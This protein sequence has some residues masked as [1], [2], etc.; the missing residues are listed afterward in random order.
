[1]K[2]ISLLVLF[3]T[4]NFLGFG[5]VKMDQIGTSVWNKDGNIFADSAISI[6]NSYNQQNKRTKEWQVYRNLNGEITDTN[7]VDL[8]EFERPVHFYGGKEHWYT[9]YDS[10]GTIIKIVAHRL[11]DTLIYDY[12]P[13]YNHKKQ[14]IKTEFTYNGEQNSLPILYS[15][16]GDMVIE[17]QADGMIIIAEKKNKQNKLVYRK[18][19]TNLPGSKK[20]I[21]IIKYERDAKGNVLLYSKE[22]DGKLV[23]KTTHFYKNGIEQFQTEK[24][25]NPNYTINTK[26]KYRYY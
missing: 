10:L 16:K 26:F 23:K 3:I 7:F 2:Q 13:F 4:I 25:F 14:L 17:N 8:D 18:T 24:F 21:E 19:I 15:Y 22:L 1:M 6:I 11:N 20:S 9:E 5:Q 12:Q